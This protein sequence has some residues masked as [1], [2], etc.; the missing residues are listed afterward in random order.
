MHLPILRSTAARGISSHGDASTIER[1]DPKAVRVSVTDRCDLA[2]TYCRPSRSDGYYETRLTVPEW[3]NV[4]RGLLASGVSRIRFTGGEPL[5]CQELPELVALA[6]RLGFC[7]I[8]LTTNAT[9]LEACAQSLKDAGLQRLTVSLDTLNAETFRTLTRGGELAPVLR[10]IERARALGFEELKLNTVVVRGVNEHEIRSLVDYAWAR[11]ITPRF[12]EI[13][14]IGEG[15]SMQHA[16]VPYEEIA[17]ALEGLFASGTPLRDPDR[18]PAKYLTSTHAPALRVGFITGASNTYCKDCDRLRVSARGEL[19]PCLATN[20]RVQAD[21][22]N[23]ARVAAQIREAWQKKPDGAV[24]KGCTEPSAKD[25]SIRQ[26][27]G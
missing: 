10:G 19:R 15:A 25:V 7:D 16:L 17:L 27:G 1:P 4:F 22:T 23:P 3:E 5:L 26:I 13:M 24:F 9:R 8:A 14:A 18:G 11:T 6:R 2:C 21:V 20:D 12:L